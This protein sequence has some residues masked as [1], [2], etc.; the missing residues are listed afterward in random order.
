MNFFPDLAK[1]FHD[2]G[3]MKVGEKGNKG[4]SRV[5]RKIDNSA[6]KNSACNLVACVN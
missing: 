2:E 1:E 4:E 5:S 3:S 6:C